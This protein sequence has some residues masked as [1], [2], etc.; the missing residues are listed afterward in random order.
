MTDKKEQP[1]DV[2]RNQFKN[3]MAGELLGPVVVPEW[4]NMEIYVAPTMSLEE[5]GPLAK[6]ANEGKFT[7]LAAITLINRARDKDGNRM[8]KT[9]HKTELMKSD[10][11]VI[12]KVVGEMNK[13]V[14]E[15]EDNLGN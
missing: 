13:L 15:V 9:V 2:I 11:R 8:F 10:Y 12:S 14:D 5:M 6:L 7:E 3:T 1:I 4:N